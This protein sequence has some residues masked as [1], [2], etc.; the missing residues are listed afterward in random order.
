MHWANASEL[1]TNPAK[2]HTISL[3]NTLS[4]TINLPTLLGNLFMLQ[5]ILVN[6]L[7]TNSPLWSLSYEWWYYCLFAFGAAAWIVKTRIRFAFGAAAIVLSALLPIKILLWGVI[8]LLG[9]A[10][11]AWIKQGKWRLHPGLG[12]FIF[13]VAMVVSRLS[14]NA[15]N[16]ENPE[17]MLIEFARDL[18]LGVAFILALASVSRLKSEMP[19]ARM[20]R[21]L[22]DFS[23]T[24]YLVHFPILMFL[25]AT[26][27]QFL[28]I[29][30]RVQPSGSGLMYLAFAAAGI[31]ACSFLIST[32][33]EANTRS[34]RRWVAHLVGDDRVS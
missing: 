8:W 22:A 1:Y 23:Y 18:G 30:F 25:V 13:A 33:T 12:L 26:G 11:Y 6:N 24:T 20:H 21:H 2:Y 28:G 3:D 10:A 15:H 32:V 19:L 31:Y 17:P 5:G 14:H 27:F 34:V 29:P 16:V 4:G 7:G 9:L